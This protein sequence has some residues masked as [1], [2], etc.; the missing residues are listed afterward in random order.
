MANACIAA[1]YFLV[2]FPLGCTL[3]QIDAIPDIM[4]LIIYPHD[5]VNN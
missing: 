5:V 3:L 4:V 2:F 1:S